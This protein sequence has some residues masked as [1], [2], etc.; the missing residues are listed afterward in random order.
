VQSLR[1]IVFNGFVAQLVQAQDPPALPELLQDHV[2]PPLGGGRLAWR[3]LRPIL[4]QKFLNRVLRC[5]CRHTQPAGSSQLHLPGGE[6]FSRH[7]AIL[8]PRILP[9]RVLSITSDIQYVVVSIRRYTPIVL[10]LSR[11]AVF[12]L[13]MLEEEEEEWNQQNRRGVCSGRPTTAREVIVQ[14]MDR[15]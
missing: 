15:L 7:R 10:L 11:R 12:P 6:D 8:H 14:P 1:E 4:R 2:V 9:N 3:H 5:G 13:S